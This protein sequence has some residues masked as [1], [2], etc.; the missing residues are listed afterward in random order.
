MGSL[1]I[2]CGRLQMPRSSSL[3]FGGTVPGSANGD[4][5]VVDDEPNSMQSFVQQD[6]IMRFSFSQKC[7]IE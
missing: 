1:G 5:G 2:R 3:S 6:M 7:I 4:M